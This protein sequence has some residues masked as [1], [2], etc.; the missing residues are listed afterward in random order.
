MRK[1]G[2]NR[3]S[4]NKVEGRESGGVG[5]KEMRLEESAE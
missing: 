1:Q 4:S 3:G 2:S 5:S